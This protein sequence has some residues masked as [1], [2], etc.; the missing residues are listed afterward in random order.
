MKYIS[1]SFIILGLFLVFYSLIS[2]RPSFFFPF[3]WIGLALLIL[4][5]SFLVL[6]FKSPKLSQYA[7]FILGLL[8][9]IN[10]YFYFKQCSNLK[11]FEVI[12]GFLISVFSLFL[13]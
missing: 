4:S 3:N 8:V 2:Y 5:I 9:M 7:L 11:G 1:I 12:G 13:K 10:T 6:R